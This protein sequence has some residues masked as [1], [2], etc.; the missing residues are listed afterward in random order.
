MINFDLYAKVVSTNLGLIDINNFKYNLGEVEVANFEKFRI[1]VPIF[2]TVE[3]GDYIHTNNWA[4]TRLDEG[5]NPVELAIRANDLKIV[6]EQQFHK[7]DRFCCKIQGDVITSSK[8]TL[9]S[10]GPSK[11]PFIRLSLRIIDEH[12]VNWMILLVGFNSTAKRI[13][14]VSRCTTINAEVTIKEKKYQ[15]GYEFKLDDFSIKK[16]A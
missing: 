9:S 11:K 4:I 2:V 16:E 7:M 12:G 6:T 13:A 15:P 8:T 10:V 5:L 1:L 3:V 14:T